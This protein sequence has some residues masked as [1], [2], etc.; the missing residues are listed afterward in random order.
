MLNFR[1]LSSTQIIFGRDTENLVGAEVKK[2]ADKVLL[3]YGE[4]ASRNRVI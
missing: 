2:Y 3:H 1:F 4:A